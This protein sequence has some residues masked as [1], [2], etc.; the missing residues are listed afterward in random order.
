MKFPNIVLSGFIILSFLFSGCHT[1]EDWSNI[2]TR[3]GK[4]YARR[5]ERDLA[6]DEWS[7]ALQI[8]RKNPEPYLLSAGIFF[9]RGEYETV[10]EYTNV[11][12]SLRADIPDPYRE[13]RDISLEKMIDTRRR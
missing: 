13:Y 12:A 4:E 9:T 1:R 3:K 2:F 8:N 11:A 7:K 6:L 10:I 5:G